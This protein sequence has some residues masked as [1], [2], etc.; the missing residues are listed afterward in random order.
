MKVDMENNFEENNFFGENFVFQK[1]FKNNFK[2]ISGKCSKFSK[3]IS[4]NSKNS[5]TKILQNFS[6]NIF[7]SRKIIFFQIF[8]GKHLSCTGRCHLPKAVSNPS[9]A[10]KLRT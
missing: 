6:K 4:K 1:K 8:F 5:T 9:L 7:S 10:I 2:K 3:K